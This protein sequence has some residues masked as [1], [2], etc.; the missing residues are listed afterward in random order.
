MRSSPQQQKFARSRRHP[1]HLLRALTNGRGVKQV[2]ENVG[3]ALG[4][5]NKEIQGVTCQA[6]V[7]QPEV[8][9]PS[10]AVRPQPDADAAQNTVL[11]K[12]AQALLTQRSAQQQ[13]QQQVAHFEGTSRALAGTGAKHC[14]D[15]SVRRVHG[16]AHALWSLPQK[17]VA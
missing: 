13:Q 9:Q 2:I 10:S 6:A 5:S 1:Q 11:F 4:I 15:G 7:L 14:A 12:C 17:L 16:Q 3:A 8:S